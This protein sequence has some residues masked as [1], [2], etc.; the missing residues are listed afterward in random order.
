M[1]GKQKAIIAVIGL[2]TATGAGGYVYKSKV[3]DA[4]DLNCDHKV[5]RIDTDVKITP[6]EALEL[7]NANCKAG[8]PNLAGAS[9]TVEV[10]LSKGGKR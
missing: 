5:E 8:P 2:F 9:D 6:K 1:T 7:I 4:I 3:I 10:T